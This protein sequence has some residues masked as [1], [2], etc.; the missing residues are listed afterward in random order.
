MSCATPVLI[1]SLLTAHVG[2][3]STPLEFVTPGVSVQCTDIEAGVYRNSYGNPSA[4]AGF[5][6]R[7]A[8]KTH[9]L[10]GAVTGYLDDPL[11]P[12]PA[13]AVVR[14]MWEGVEIAVMPSTYPVG[15]SIT[16]RVALD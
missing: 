14:E 9:V 16:M 5:R 6:Y 1:L 10:V 4:Y 13:V 2:D 7:A 12:L 11:R 15:I 8:N 3:Y